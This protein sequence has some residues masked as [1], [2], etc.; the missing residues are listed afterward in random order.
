MDL[1]RFS[2]A[3]A[4]ARRVAEDFIALG[5]ATIQ[6]R[7]RFAVAL[8]GGSTPKKLHQILVADFRDA[9]DWSKVDFYLG[10]DRFVPPADERSNER[11]VRQTL[12]YP[13]GIS[14][15]HIFM[16]YA[17]LDVLDAAMQYDSRL[18]DAL[19][20][21]LLGLGTDG[22]TLSLFPGDPFVTGRKA[23]AA[24]APVVVAD[25]ITLTAEYANQSAQAWFLVAGADK[26]AAMQQMLQ[27]DYDPAVTP[28]QA[29]ARKHPHCR[30]FADEAALSF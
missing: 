7:S 4:L 10:D 22:H 27:G 9:I 12:L 25:R 5:N 14:E 21:V 1:Y 23:V 3:D 28:S 8:S 24:K 16:P 15:S 26:Q 2:D 19:D 29:I 11:M 13:L 30:V 6:E 20:L 17:D 18:P